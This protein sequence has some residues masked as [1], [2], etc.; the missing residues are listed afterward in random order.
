MTREV[1]GVFCC[2]VDNFR[3][4]D[5]DRHWP[6]RRAGFRHQMT[7]QTYFSTV[8]GY[9]CQFYSS[10]LLP[11][12][13]IT[14]LT[15]TSCYTTSITKPIVVQSLLLQ[16]LFRG[17]QPNGK[18]SWRW[19]GLAISLVYSL[20]SLGETGSSDIK[21]RC[22]LWVSKAYLMDLVCVGSFVSTRDRQADE[23]QNGG[24]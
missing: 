20:V 19:L 24:L 15:K 11:P 8:P 18:D 23:D 22:D 13:H 6:W 1:P 7:A 2:S 3:R 5:V 10:R 12:C 21:E 17:S 4:V 9:A 14:Q 16:S